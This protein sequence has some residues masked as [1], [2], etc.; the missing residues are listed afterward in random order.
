MEK[1]W[2]TVNNDGIFIALCYNFDAIRSD[3]FEDDHIHFLEFM[4]KIRP[5]YL[6]SYQDV[7]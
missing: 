3:E 6:F 4:D 5:F 7:H 1:I 2:K